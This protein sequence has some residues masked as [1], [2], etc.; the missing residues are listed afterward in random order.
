MTHSRDEVKLEEIIDLSHRLVH[1]L[2]IVD[3]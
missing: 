1:A 2:N 3:T